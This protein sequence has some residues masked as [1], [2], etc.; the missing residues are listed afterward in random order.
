VAG[1]GLAVAAPVTVGCVLT[2]RK[3]ASLGI[4]RNT[5]VVELAAVRAP[6]ERYDVAILGGGLAGLTLSIQ[7]KRARP[8]TSV[9]VLEKREGPAPLAAFKVGESTVAAGAH[10]FS[11]VVGMAAHLQRDQLK[12][13]GLRYFPPADG[14][15]D[16]LARTELGVPFFPPHDNFQIDRGLFE[17]RLAARARALGVDLQQGARVREVELGGDLHRIAFEQFD[18]AGATAARWVIDAAGR[19]AILRRKLGLTT[20]CGHHINSAWFRLAGGLDIEDWGRQNATW[21][22]RMSEPGLRMLSTNH[23]L[24]EGY[25]VW[26]IPLAT[27]PISIGVCADPRLHPFERISEF[28]A[29]LEWLHAHE[30]QLAEAVA[31]RIGDV[32]DFLRV[33]DFAYGVKQ[34]FSAERW[35]LV[36]EAAAFTD[37][38]YSPGSDFIG[39]SNSFAGDLVVRDLD[40][41]QIAERVA[42]FNDAYQRLFAT[43][44]ARYRDSYP[45]FGNAWVALGF[46]TWDFYAA[47]VGHNLLFVHNKLTDREF[48]ARADAAI[49]QLA[50]LNARMHDLCREWNE[51][52][53]RER[54]PTMPIPPAIMIQALLGLAGE[55]ADDDALLEALTIHVRNSEALA[56][57]IWERATR[58]LPEPPPA[59]APINPYA[60]SL[61][62]A[63][64]AADGLFDGSGITIDEARTIAAGIDNIWDQTL[65][66]AEVFAAAQQG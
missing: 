51:L 41:E 60:V 59:D 45:L 66:P 21:M 38:F 43:T 12:K 9:V 4:E 35:A 37:P 30:P 15:R 24:G 28:G 46:L 55:Y 23:L 65:E 40:G 10:Y 42:Y 5:S 39:Y 13:C 8:Q 48:M 47:H 27:G 18:A 64:W 54:P 1:G 16:L 31:G 56:I 52:E 26:L 57:A 7:L 58:A 53:R 33:E 3:G 44:I 62:P 49:A 14:N 29:L 6:A 11:E 20:D 2:V 25:W 36:G 22:A 50:A 63:R 19:A 17:N 61:D 32:E 34:A